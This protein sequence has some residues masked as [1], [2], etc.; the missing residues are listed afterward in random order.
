MNRRFVIHLLGHLLLLTAAFLGVPLLAAAI[1]AEPL[2]PFLGSLMV[3]AF[4]GAAALRLSR[5]T[6]HHRSSTGPRD[7]GYRPTTDCA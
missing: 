5:P 6:S 7:C 4:A 2:A 1:F 3:A